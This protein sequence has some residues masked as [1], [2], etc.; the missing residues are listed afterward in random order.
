M[1][2]AFGRNLPSAVLIF[3]I[4]WVNATND[5][6]RKK[7]LRQFSPLRVAFVR[8]PVAASRE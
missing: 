1:Y 6:S 7:R 3:L 5:F 8:E 4:A 2:P